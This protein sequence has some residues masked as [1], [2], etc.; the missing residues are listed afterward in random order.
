MSRPPS[1]SGFSLLEVLIVLLVVSAATAITTSAMFRPSPAKDEQ[2]FARDLQSMMED[3]RGG[4]LRTGQA[5]HVVFDPERK[6]VGLGDALAGA[7]EIPE[8][9][10]VRLTYDDDL[11]RPGIAFFPDGGS[12]GG[13]FEIERG[14][15]VRH[16]EIDWLL[17][18]TRWRDGGGLSNASQ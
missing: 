1:Q 16:L 18:V 9:V 12:T 11:A 17:G 14:D 13:T 15:Q 4:A 2:R 10:R 6:L 8:S 7:I 3:A 5:T